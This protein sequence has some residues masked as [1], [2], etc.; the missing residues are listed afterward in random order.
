MVT[1]DSFRQTPWL[2]AVGEAVSE[3]NA[4][5][6][7]T[8]REL[9]AL[10]N[11]DPDA[12]FAPPYAKPYEDWCVADHHAAKSLDASFQ[13]ECSAI[14]EQAYKTA[15]KWLPIP[16]FCGL[17]SDDVTTIYALLII[18]NNQLRSFTAERANWYVRGRVPWGYVGNYP[19]GKW[20]IL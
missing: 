9:E 13:A 10:I 6:F 19:D 4:Q 8:H 7:G 17:V 5:L 14:S 3:S 11:D 18:T 15:W 1:R 12:F 16:E 2:H 20:I